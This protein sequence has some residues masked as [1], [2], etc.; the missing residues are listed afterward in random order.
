MVPR[1][2]PH[3][4]P[5]HPQRAASVNSAK[6]SYRSHSSSFEA[7][8]ERSSSA[9]HESMGPDEAFRDGPP[10]YP[11]EDTRLT[12][13]KELSGWYAYGF[14]AEV[15]VICGMGECLELFLS[16]GELHFTPTDATS[17]KAYRNRAI[18]GSWADSRFHILV[19]AG[20]S[21]WKSSSMHP[22]TL[23]YQIR[24]EKRC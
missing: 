6:R 15:F 4:R 18:A 12:G 10:Q 16:S 7:D 2:E 14:A 17:F 1:S 3:P 5:Q 8:D 19:L 13:R 21:S 11:G 23:L 24:A 20:S 9:D 22:N